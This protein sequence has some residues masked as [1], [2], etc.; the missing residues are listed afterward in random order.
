MTGVGTVSISSNAVISGSATN[1]VTGSIWTA[2]PFL[3]DQYAEATIASVPAGS[4]QIGV[5][6]R[7]SG[8]T[9]GQGYLCQHVASG[10]SL[11]RLI[12]GGE[13]FQAT[14][15]HN[16]AV[17]DRIRMSIVGN[18]YTCSVTSATGVVTSLSNTDANFPTGNPGVTFFN[19]NGGSLTNFTAGTIPNNIA[20]VT[21]TLGEQQF[22]GINHFMGPTIFGN[23]PGVSTGSGLT[24]GNLYIQGGITDLSVSSGGYLCTD[25]NK[26]YTTNCTTGWFDNTTNGIGN[27]TNVSNSVVITAG[28]FAGNTAAVWNA[29]Y[30]NSINFSNDQYAAITLSTITAGSS[31]VDACVRMQTANFSGYCGGIN[32]NSNTFFLKR[33]AN[34]VTTTLASTVITPAVGDYYQITAV[35][36][37][38][39]VNRF[40]NGVLVN[41]LGPISDATYTSGK[42]GIGIFGNFSRGDNFEAG[43]IASLAK[44]NQEQG[45]T[46][47]QHFVNGISLGNSLGTTVLLTSSGNSGVVA[48]TSGTLTSGDIPKFDASGNVIDASIAATALVLN[49]AANTGTAAMTLDMS[50]STSAAALRVP[51]IAGAS[52]TTSGVLSYDTTNKNIHTGANAVDNIVGIIPSSIAPANND[53]VKWT[54]AAGVLTLNTAGAACGSGGGSGALSAITAAVGSNSINNGDN[55]QTWN[56][57]LTT[58]AKSAFTFTENTAAINGA[59]SQ[60]LLNVATILGSTA[61]PLTVSNSL[62]GSQTLPTVSIK[63]TW[64]TSGVVDAALL[65]NPTNTTSGAGSLLIDAQLGGTSQWKADKDGNTTQLGTASLGATAPSCTPG[66]GGGSCMQ[67]GSG[68]AAGANYDTLYASSADH[69][70]HQNLNNGGDIPVPNRVMLAS[71]YTN[72]TTTA[73]NIT[74]LTFTAAV[75]ANYAMTCELYYSA[76]AGTA[77][78]DITITGP[79]S[80][81]NVF[82]SYD[83]DAT[84]TSLQNSVA[85]AFATKLVGNA[86][87]T[88]ST[89]LHATVTLGLQNGANSGAVQVQGSATGAGTVTIRPGSFCVI[90]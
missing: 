15:G 48:E 60:F 61:V 38:I 36:S 53:C 25:A 82:Y 55:A 35:G 14:T 57:A 2:T 7:L 9:S 24:N 43:N 58:A 28:Q 67:E 44:L 54:V 86:T 26:K 50:A 90:Y 71:A 89:N 66:S 52:S 8:T 21:T 23:Y 51:N 72:A 80:P 32:T 13:A 6:V 12:A 16:A 79:A 84:S 47:P 46:A 49:N 3:S 83:E 10:L 45:W 33:V 22:N 31:E 70:L 87:V 34:A 74:G 75:S 85:S 62:N 73:S 27:Y 77:G 5:G 4:A 59:G 42:A 64:N 76:S 40:A 56:W 65:I 41:T 39:T 63:P 68:P 37:N 88:A 81:T 78:L 1:A 69:M 29:A 20:Y 18:N 17:G 11:Y 30:V 19:A